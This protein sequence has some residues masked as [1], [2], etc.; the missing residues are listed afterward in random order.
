[1]AARFRLLWIASIL[2]F[3]GTVALA[4]AAVVTIKFNPP[5]GT[6]YTETFKLTRTLERG[7]QRKVLEGQTVTNRKF[8]KT[9]DGF[10]MVAT[11]VSS[12][13]SEDGTIVSEKDS[14]AGVSV[15]YDFDPAGK[16]KIVRGFDT[17]LPK[18]QASLPKEQA[19]KV[20]EKLLQEQAMAEWNGRYGQF[21]GFSALLGEPRV[22]V[23]PFP[24]PRGKALPVYGVRRVTSKPN[25]HGHACVLIRMDYGTDAQA[26]AKLTGLPADKI[27]AAKP[28]ADADLDTA[29]KVVVTGYTEAV[30]DP[31]TML[32]YEQKAGHTLMAPIAG[33][34]AP[35]RTSETRVYTFDYPPAK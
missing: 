6:T 22:D 25:V 10:S 13:I 2:L 4:G 31:E 12:Q 33:Q 3:A 16:L 29:S 35:G 15:T 21:D 23:E 19:D 20:T 32:L 9:A 34:T 14:L 11:R 30:V 1:M 28:P 18:I 24:S 17:V 27:L 7:V 26:L 8:A 5:D